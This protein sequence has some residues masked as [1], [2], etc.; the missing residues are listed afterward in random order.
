MEETV[1]SNLDNLAKPI[2]NHPQVI[3]I[4]MGGINHKDHNDHKPSSNG[5]FM[6]LG[7]EFRLGA[8]TAPQV[9]RKHQPAGKAQEAGAEHELGDAVPRSGY[10]INY[11]ML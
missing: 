6:A 1:L 10:V 9:K 11:D 2:V 4:F 7:Q 8:R 5:S 3:T